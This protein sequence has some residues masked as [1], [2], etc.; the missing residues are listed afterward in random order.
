[1]GAAV[2]AGLGPPGAIAGVGIGTAV[3]VFRNFM[4]DA[5][6]EGG[7]VSRFVAKAAECDKQARREAAARKGQQGNSM[8]AIPPQMFVVTRTFGTFAMYSYT[9]SFGPTSLNQMVYET[10]GPNPRDPVTTTVGQP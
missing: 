2:G 1:M 6:L 4:A 9:I 8:E 7:P 10:H 3:G 5:K